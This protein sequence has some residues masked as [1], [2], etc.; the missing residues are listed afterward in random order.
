[1]R[2]T[3]SIHV[4]NKFKLFIFIVFIARTNN[5]QNINDKVADNKNG[6]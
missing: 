5:T 6:C 3:Y 1:M 4:F 2:T